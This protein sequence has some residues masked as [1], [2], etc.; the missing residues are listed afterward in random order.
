MEKIDFAAL[1]KQP[2]NDHETAENSPK[3]A[4]SRALPDQFPTKN[5]KVG[6]SNTMNINDNNASA[7]LARPARPENEGGGII[8]DDS[9]APEGVSTEKSCAKNWHPIAVYLLLSVV[10]KI[11]S[12]G[13]EVFHVSES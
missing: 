7:R 6:Q 10:K 9:P 1:V 2:E 8:N 5:E 12:G 11:H 3:Q 13:E 4:K